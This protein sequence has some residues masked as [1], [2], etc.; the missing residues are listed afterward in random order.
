VGGTEQTIG[1]N[2]AFRTEQGSVT[3]L[4][5]VACFVTSTT[6]SMEV[7]NAIAIDGALKV[8]LKFDE[9]SGVTAADSSKNANSGALVNGPLWTAGGIGGAVDL[10]GVNDHVTL[11]AGQA[12]F[13]NG[14]TIAV[15]SYPVSVKSSARFIDFG[16]GT[17]N[18]NIFL[19]RNGTLNDLRFRVYT[20]SNG[21]NAVVATN[22]IA[23]NQWQHFAATLDSTGNVK[24]YK[25]GAQVGSG[26]V[27][28]PLNVTRTNNFIGR[29]NWTIDEYFDGALDD[30]RIY[31]RAL[32]AAEVLALP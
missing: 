27:S 8:W 6:G 13:T 30:L 11:P 15:W 26:T 21:G 3:Q 14:M 25:N 1:L 16:N 22:V 23:L 24:L 7:C 12:N 10:D 4:N 19:H 18:N 31:N 2:Y 17:S 20:G 29:S 28:V 5:N 9:S 32:S